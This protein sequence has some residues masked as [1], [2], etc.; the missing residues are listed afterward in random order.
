MIGYPKWLEDPE[1]LDKYYENVSCCSL[2][3]SNSYMRSLWPLTSFNIMFVFMMFFASLQS[4][5]KIV[6]RITWKPDDSFT[7]SP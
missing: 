4:A 1:K 5:L 6:L 3:I 2:T 7:I